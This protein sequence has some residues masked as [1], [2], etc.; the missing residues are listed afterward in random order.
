MAPK[1]N[2]GKIY[3]IFS[4]E[5][6]VEYIGSTTRSLDKR[7]SDH[8][9]GMLS[10]LKGAKKYCYSIEVL[11]FNDADI[12]LIE[13]FPCNNCDELHAQEGIYIRQSIKEGLNIGQRIAGRTIKEWVKDNKEYLYVHRK[14]YREAH[15]DEI[16]AKKGAKIQ[17][18]CGIMSN[19]SHIARHKRTVKHQK[20]E[21]NKDIRY[22]NIVK[23]C[24]KEQ[25]KEYR[26]NHAEEIKERKARKIQCECG[27]MS[28]S[29]HMA[30]HKKTV[31][32][33][34]W[35]AENYKINLL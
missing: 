16:K 22:D 11:K 14:E 17:C 33:Q 4:Q 13:D 1:Y 7:F 30:R 19:S 32:H 23:K 28:N 8:K 3:R 20:W 24:K 27:S 34:K 18:E 2:K 31:K 29:S 5:G 10:F 25:Q 12:E 15:K 9:F 26:V 6:N 21:E 35:E